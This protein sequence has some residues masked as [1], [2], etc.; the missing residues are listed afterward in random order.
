[1]KNYYLLAIVFILTA[2]FLNIGVQPL[3]LEE[4]R[5]A[6]VA[7]EML[8]AGNLWVPLQL[9][10]Y[11]YFKPPIYNWLIILSVTLF[12]TWEEW[13]IR[14]PSVLS[15]ISLGVLVYLVG[16]RHHS[17]EMGLT[18]ALFFMISIDI[19]FYFSL[20]AEIDL[21]YSLITFGVLSALLH[22]SNTQQYHWMYLSAYLLSAVGFLTK[23]MPSIVFLGL[24]ILFTCYHHRIWKKFFHPMHFIS[25]FLFL[26]IVGGYFL[27]YSQFNDPLAFL[28]GI[29]TQSS[30]RTA[31][32]H[33]GSRFLSHILIFP[34][35]LFKNTLP[36]SLLLLFY[37]K[38]TN[39]SIIKGHPFL[40]FSLGML[41]LQL[42]LY[43]MSPGAKQRYIYMLYP[44]LIYLAVGVYIHL[45]K[46]HQWLKTLSIVL[47]ALLLIG[48][49]G[50]YAFGKNYL[51]FTLAWP[52]ILAVILGLALVGLL[53]QKTWPTVVV[54]VLAFSAMR[55]VF[56]LVVLPQRASD[57]IAQSDKERAAAI[58]NHIEEQPLYLYIEG[59]VPII[60]EKE[61]PL[62]LTMVF[63][64]NKLRGT[65][66]KSKRQWES[67][68]YYLA[69]KKVVP[70]GI[71]TQFEHQYGRE[72]IVLVQYP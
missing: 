18:A 65:T 16:K 38:K 70:Q 15:F 33:P 56:D 55:I 48:G 53:R 37:F 10:E 14:I 29:W 57:S 34:V 58:V 54:S 40:Q 43:W 12:Q 67:G 22:F 21:F 31:I 25:G 44:F 2:L 1:M 47:T 46:S 63:Y 50:L 20:L 24:G 27:Y 30:Q 7:M 39:W 51:P 41:A 42:L 49:I 62:S 36:V 66:L 45:Q 8:E 3:F 60:E 19:L 11:Y 61:L 72:T 32:E 23:G 52:S 9:G 6:I 69:N 59:D 28:E 35:D 5:R 71:P 68:K 26:G 13:A 4:P 64:L 17:R